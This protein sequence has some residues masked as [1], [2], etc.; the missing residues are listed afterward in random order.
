MK[1]NSSS[2]ETTSGAKII[3]LIS[4]EPVKGALK[5]SQD[6]K[7][8]TP[9]VVMLDVNSCTIR[10]ILVDTRSATNVLLVMSHYL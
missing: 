6:E 5:Q 2:Q 10:R 4:S 8:D 1:N 9:L 3:N 7:D